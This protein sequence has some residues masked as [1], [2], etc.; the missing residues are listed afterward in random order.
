MISKYSGVDDGQVKRMKI[1]F[2]VDFPDFTHMEKDGSSG[3]DVAKTKE[4]RIYNP[5]TFRILNMWRR[6]ISQV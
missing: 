2:S 6:M 1:L 5:W 4:S 3:V